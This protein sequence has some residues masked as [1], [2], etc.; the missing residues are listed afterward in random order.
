MNATCENCRHWHEDERG[1]CTGGPPTASMGD[2]AWSHDGPG[3]HR[4][5]R[6]VWPWTYAHQVCGAWS[7]AT[8]EPKV[9]APRDTRPEPGADP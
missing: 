2:L 7:P 4:I 9:A 8:P 5:G 3:S 6:A 1:R